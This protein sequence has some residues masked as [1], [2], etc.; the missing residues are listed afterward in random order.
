MIHLARL[1]GNARPAGQLA[2]VD[3]SVSCRPTGCRRTRMQSEKNAA[4]GGRMARMTDH[5][6]AVAD[7]QPHATRPSQFYPVRQFTQD[8]TSPTAALDSGR[9]SFN[10]HQENKPGVPNV[11]F[12]LF[13]S[14]QPTSDTYAARQAGPRRRTRR[15]QLGKDHQPRPRRPWTGDS[16]AEPAGPAAMPGGAG[17]HCRGGQSTTGIRAQLLRTG[18]ISAH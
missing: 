9:P 12:F 5:D 3:R 8:L 15:P 16:S 1:A 13:S 7:S 10:L 2:K 11:S 6:Q 18:A 14:L 17:Q 4:P